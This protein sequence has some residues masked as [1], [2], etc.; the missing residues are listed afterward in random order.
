MDS[1]VMHKEKS[2]EIPTWLHRVLL[3]KKFRIIRHILFW[4]FIY[5][6][7]LLSL[8]GLTEPLGYPFYLEIL[9]LLAD[10]F[11]V[12]VNI[13]YL[14]PR[15]FL[16][17]KVLL[18]LLL[19]ILSVSAVILWNYWIW[20]GGALEGTG[21]LDADFYVYEEGEKIRLFTYWITNSW[22]NAGLVALAV[23]FKLFEESYLSSKK[24]R[25]LRE[26]KLNAELA[27]LKT[28][29]NPH[30]LFNTLN[31]MYVMSQKKSD[32]LPETI[33]QLSELLRYQLYETEEDTVPMDKEVTYLRNY[34]EL[35]LL[36]RQHLKLDFDV[37]GDLRG[38]RIRPLILLPYI[39]NAFKYSNSGTGSD[40][41]E[42]KMNIDEED[43]LT[44][45]VMNTKGSLQRR[46]VGGIGMTNAKR[47]LELAYPDRHTL[48]IEEDEKRFWV[49]LRL[50]LG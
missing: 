5:A 6:D 10:M 47:R 17:G 50:A 40:R 45:S 23:A 41:I 46:D 43:N 28:Q 27:Y 20:I 42:I 7:E 22:S 38:K 39:E 16:R 24:I 25:D 21:M 44:F 1:F 34:L 32:A 48:D 35:E 18:Y 31:N 36:R 37:S 3:D 2:M 9:D 33:M 26:D 49:R 4:I 12:Y 19:T 14:L 30:F 15:F 13:Y 11:M 8:L 29:V